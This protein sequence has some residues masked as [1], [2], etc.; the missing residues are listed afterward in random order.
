MPKGYYHLTRDIQSQMYALKSTGISLQ[1]IAK[2]VSLEALKIKNKL[3][4]VFNF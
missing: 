4:F 3:Q 2:F 1:K